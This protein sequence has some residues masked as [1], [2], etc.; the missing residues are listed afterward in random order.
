VI[1]KLHP[2]E[3]HECAIREVEKYAPG[4]LVFTEGNTNHMIA[5][6]DALITR[7]SSVILVALAM[8]RRVY[9]DLSEEELE[10]LAPLQNGGTSAQRIADVCRRHLA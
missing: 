9:S 4:S 3:N 7:Y 5:N 10:T 8:G 6:S 1:F 2:S